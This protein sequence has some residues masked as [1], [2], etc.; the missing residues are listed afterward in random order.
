MKKKQQLA[1]P[2]ALAGVLIVAA[3]A[4]ALAMLAPGK[5]GTALL[6]GLT[7]PLLWGAIELL[8]KGD[9]KGA[10]IAVVAASV[11]LSLS[12]G[13][14]VAQAA[15]LIGPDEGR[16][17][18]T[19]FGITGGLVLAFFGNRI[20]KMLERYNPEMD[21]ARR[22]AFQRMAGWVFVLTGLASALAWLLLPIEAAR[23]WATLIVAGGTLL[24]LARIVQCRLRGRRA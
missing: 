1:L 22:Q 24:V 13:V 9:K 21:V 20:P 6:G 12:L 18:L 19:L 3:L 16:L 2:L 11:L 23:L 8:T 15:Q 7:L 4:A 5:V 10:R 17:G 14:K